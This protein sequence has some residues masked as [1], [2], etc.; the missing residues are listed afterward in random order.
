MK[1]DDRLEFMKW[2]E[3]KVKSKARFNFKKEINEYCCSDV[4]ILRRACGK[5]RSMFMQICKFDQFEEAIT[6]LQACAKNMAK[7]FH[8]SRNRGNHTISRIR[9]REEILH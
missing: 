8:A 4:D 6:M 5:F 3:Q 9:Q 2:Y 7:R 1:P